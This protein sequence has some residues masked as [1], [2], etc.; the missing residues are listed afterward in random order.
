MATRKQ[1]SEAES[2]SKRNA[3]A[4]KPILFVSGGN[5][6]PSTPS[7]GYTRS[8]DWWQECRDLKIGTTAIQAGGTKYLPQYDGETDA[9]Y[10]TRRLL[11]AVYN[12]YERTVD[13]CVGLIMQKPIELGKDMPQ[14][15]VTLW[16]NFDNAGNH[17]DLVASD[18]L[19]D[20]I[21]TGIAGLL[22]EYPRVDATSVTDART[23][24]DL[25]LRPYAIVVRRED[26][27][28]V[29]FAVINGKKTLTMLIIR[30]CGEVEDGEFGTA[31]VT[32]Y[33]VYRRSTVGAPVVTIS[34]YETPIGNPDAKAVLVPEKSGVISKQTEIPWAPLI[35]GKELGEY[36]I[37]PAMLALADLNIDHHRVNTEHRNLMRLCNVP[38]WIRKGFVAKK[39]PTT[40]ADI[41]EKLNMGPEDGLD[42]PADEYSDFFWRS[43]DSAPL[44]HDQQEIDRIEQRMG[45]AGMAFIAPQTTAQETAAAKRIDSSAQNSTL[46]TAAR[47]LED[48]LELWFQFAC[49]YTGETSGSV[50]V[51]R[52]F[53]RLTADPAL[54]QVMV[55]AAANNLIP[56][57]VLLAAFQKYQLMPEGAD[58]QAMLSELLGSRM[59]GLTFPAKTTEPAATVDPN[60]DPLQ[61]A[62]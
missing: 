57:E 48:C 15:M 14:S 31:D 26:I 60:A 32:R 29:R 55:T 22:A 50:T 58:I 59:L 56:L 37:K 8:K 39:D 2:R 24:A 54:L 30:E 20:S 61:K 5:N 36:E 13:A 28:R 11:C 34:V 10:A 40:G 52:E 41:P 7:K 38:K 43:P 45:S 12:G 23:E 27:I 3:K 4:S 9:S 1:A 44:D 53:E 16:E 33:R 51:N 49:N 19:D 47:R 21:T 35:T 6:D 17:G 42:L 25:G 62:A 46:S 18:L